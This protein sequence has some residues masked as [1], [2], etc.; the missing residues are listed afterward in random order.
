MFFCLDNFLTCQATYKDTATTQ[1]FIKTQERKKAAL[2][3]GFFYLGGLSLDA[4]TLSARFIV[5]EKVLTT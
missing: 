4:N 2:R 3:G 5:L 1:T